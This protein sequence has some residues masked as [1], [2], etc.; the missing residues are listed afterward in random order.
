MA[1]EPLGEVNHHEVAIGAAAD[2]VEQVRALVGISR[3]ASRAV[4]LGDSAEDAVTETVGAAVTGV[5]QQGL[6]MRPNHAGQSASHRP[7]LAFFSGFFV[8]PVAESLHL[9]AKVVFD[10]VGMEPVF[11]EALI[12]VLQQP[13]AGSFSMF[14]ASHA[15]SHQ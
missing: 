1:E 5:D 7:D 6:A 3:N 8:E 2:T 13:L 10:G 11:L 4:I 9:K 15:V 12:Q 14:V